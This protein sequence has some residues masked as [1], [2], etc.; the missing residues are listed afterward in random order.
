MSNERNVGGVWDDDLTLICS[1]LIVS[2]SLLCPGRALCHH[3]HSPLVRSVI[4][5][6]SEVREIRRR[7]KLRFVQSVEY[8]LVLA[9][10]TAQARALL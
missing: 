1:G 6:L 2:V 3:S 8:P 4:R 9:V 5:I 10:T 7:D